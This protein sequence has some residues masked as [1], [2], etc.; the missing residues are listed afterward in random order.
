MGLRILCHGTRQRIICDRFQHSLGTVHTY[1]KRVLRALKA[2]AL[3]VVKPI[4]R[5]EVQ[6]E[7]Q[8]DP[9]WYPHFKVYFSWN[10]IHYDRRF[11][12]KLIR[13]L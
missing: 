3:N 2:F 4:N 5:G 1:F 10:F 11:S 9:R 7:I 12:F 6:P 13:V 8:A